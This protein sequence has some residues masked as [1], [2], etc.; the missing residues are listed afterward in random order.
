MDNILK[1]LDD[2]LRQNN[3][4]EYRTQE[5]ARCL[6]VTYCYMNEITPDTADSILY[7]LFW[8]NAVDEVASYEE[9]CDYMLALI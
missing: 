8:D 7:G 9:F 3:W 2:Y 1:S 4:E 5:I 6:F